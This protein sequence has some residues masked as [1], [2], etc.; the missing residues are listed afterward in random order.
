[1]PQ[2]DGVVPYWI[3]DPYTLRFR[4]ADGRHQVRWFVR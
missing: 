2:S 4:K 3:C 1:M